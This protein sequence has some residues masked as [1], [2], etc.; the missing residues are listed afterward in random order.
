MGAVNES[1]ENLADVLREVFGPE[2]DAIREKAALDRRDD[3]LLD[4][5]RRLLIR[6]ASESF[7]RMRERRGKRAQDVVGKCCDQC[8]RRTLRQLDSDGRMPRKVPYVR[9]YNALQSCRD[10]DVLIKRLDQTLGL[11]E[12]QIVRSQH[13]DPDRAKRESAARYLDELRPLLM[14]HVSNSADTS[15]DEAMSAERSALSK[16]LDALLEG[17]GETYDSAIRDAFASAMGADAVEGALDGTDLTSRAQKVLR[18]AF[19]ALDA[20]EERQYQLGREDAREVQDESL[21]TV[22]ITPFD[23]EVDASA[24]YDI[25][26]LALLSKEVRRS[27]VTYQRVVRDRGLFAAFVD[28]GVYGECSGFSIGG[29]WDEETGSLVEDDVVYTGGSSTDEVKDIPDFVPGTRR[30]SPKTA[31]KRMREFNQRRYGGVFDDDFQAHVEA[32]W[33][34]FKKLMTFVNDM[35]GDSDLRGDL[36]LWFAKVKDELL[37]KAFELGLKMDELQLKEFERD[38]MDLSDA[39]K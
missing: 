33:Y 34:G 28:E 19:E 4:E 32:F 37:A 36:V 27:F 1:N 15:Y 30:D 23:V 18:Q 13:V 11:A 16:K 29:W 21:G 31:I 17:S 25:V 38:V 10:T 7:R 20:L 39:K 24:R 5:L 3:R 8:Q 6:E 9:I 12:Q 26:E 2:N 22:G 35:Y 14:V